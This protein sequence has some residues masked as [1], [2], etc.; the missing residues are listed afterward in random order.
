M[1]TKTELKIQAQNLRRKGYSYSEIRKEVPVAKST[2]T[3]WLREIGL[4]KRQK[5]RLTQRRLEA[6]LRGAQ[7]R[8]QDRILRTEEIYSRSA[9]EVKSISKRELWLIGIA[10]YWA[11]GSKEKPNYRGAEVRF[12]NSDPLMIKLFLK[13]LVEVC[14]VPLERIKF[15]LYIHENCKPRLNKVIDFWSRCTNIS[16]SEFKYIYFKKNKINTLRKNVGEDYFGVLRISVKTSSEL[17][18]K[19]TG[20]V[21]GINKYCRVV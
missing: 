9:E 19:I 6:A 15:S 2:L 17:N 21:R 11:E 13:W 4:V 7:K 1:K 16:R 12:S 14:K 18:R 5:Q 10:L 20:W 3:L 8:K